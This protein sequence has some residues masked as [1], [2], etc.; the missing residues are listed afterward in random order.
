[1]PRQFLK[2]HLPNAHAI[3]GRRE[4]RLLGRL[5]EDPF[6]LHLNRRSV[7]GGV[8]VGLFVAFVPLPIQMPMAAAFAV[9]F[10]VNLILSVALVWV[11][12]PVTIPPLFYFT[13]LVGTW[14]LGTPVLAT[15]FRPSLAW[16]WHQLEAI[17]QPLFLGSFIVGV[18]TALAGYGAVHLIWRLHILWHLKRRRE[19]RVRRQHDRSR[20]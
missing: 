17:W 9:L 14:V 15:G 12:N 6:L 3:R 4:L 10:R 20:A 1:M 2:R 8:A 7:A 5:L 19:R 18:V 11:S 13:Y 16:F